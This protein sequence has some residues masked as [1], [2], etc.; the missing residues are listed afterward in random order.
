[1]CVRLPRVVRKVKRDASFDVVSKPKVS[2][3]RQGHVQNY[4][5]AHA[6][7]ESLGEA[8]RL[9]HLIFQRKNLHTQTATEEKIYRH[10]MR[11]WSKT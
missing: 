6:Y 5:D 1:M 2:H 9:P 8:F 11:L 10:R 4:D 3:R 7:I